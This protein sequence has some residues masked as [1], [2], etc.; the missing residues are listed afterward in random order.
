MASADEHGARAQYISALKAMIGVKATEAVLMRETGIFPGRLGI[1]HRDVLHALAA[2]EADVGIIFHHLAR[3][4]ATA[5]PQACAM[6]LCLERNNS[7]GLS[8]SPPQLTR[9]VR[10]LRRLLLNISSLS[11]VPSILVMALRS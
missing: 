8:R 10:T 4:F 7:R 1:Q 3:Y 9:C 5:Y 6:V 2:G 11:P